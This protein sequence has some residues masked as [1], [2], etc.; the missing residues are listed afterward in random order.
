M[1]VFAVV[2]MLISLFLLY[3][4]AYPKRPELKKNDDT[5]RKRDIDISEVVI[6]T[7]F[8][9]PDFGQPQPT[10]TISEKEDVLEKKPYIFA[11]GNEN[12]NA[13]IPKEKLDEVFEEVNPEDLEIE[14]EEDEK[15]FK[16]FKDFKESEDNRDDWDD[17][18]FEIEQGAE[19]ASGMSIEEMT[20]AAKAIDH[21]TDE[22][23]GI[24]FKVEKTDMFE[25]LVSGDEGKAERIK[26]IIDR[27]F[28]N[29]QPEIESATETESETSDTEYSNF[30]V[31]DFL[32][33]S[34]RTFKK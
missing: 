27:H 21:P 5:H 4:I 32:G 16:E 9:R 23:A 6:T 33:Q 24:L 15:E 13:V 12:R 30:D 18:G 7:R 22:K 8:V 10:R 34:K 11:A 29:V 20:E 14:P 2:V 25:Q 31:A 26:A 3:R 28:R 19:L 17:E 1:K